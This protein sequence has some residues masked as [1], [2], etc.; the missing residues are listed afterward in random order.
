QQF[1][2]LKDM[3]TPSYESPYK[4]HMA[5]ENFADAPVRISVFSDFQCPFCKLVSEQIP[6]LARGYEDKVNIQ[7]LFYPLDNACNPELKREMHRFACKA[8]YLA[9]CDKEKFVEDGLSRG[10]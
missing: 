9:A 5:T 6:D 8:A 2:T 3:G 1:E 4:I 10:L 7:Y